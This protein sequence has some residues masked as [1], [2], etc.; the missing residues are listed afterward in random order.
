MKRYSVYTF[1]SSTVFAV[2]LTTV[3][4][5]ITEE[6]AARLGKDL[7]P[8]GGEMAG[9]AD[10]TIPKY[11]GGITK[12]LLGYKVGDHHPD[13]YANDKIIFT[14][15][16]E[17]MSQYSD[18]LTDANKRLLE[19]YSGTYT[20]PVYPTRRSASFPKFIE[21][22]TRNNCAKNGLTNNGNGISMLTGGIPFPIPKSGVEVIWNLSLIHISEPTRPY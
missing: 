16:S 22:N 18:K 6:E 1:V 20:M 21:E 3:S 4:A 10:G 2:G 13:P 15:T 5:E 12:P 7:T 17:N 11:E 9:N 19:Q 8:L 14:I